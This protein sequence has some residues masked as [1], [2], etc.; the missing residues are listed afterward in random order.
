MIVID[1]LG[2]FNDYISPEELRLPSTTTSLEK[3]LTV[4]KSPWLWCCIWCLLSY[5]NCQTFYHAFQ[6]FTAIKVHYRVSVLIKVFLYVSQCERWWFLHRKSTVNPFLLIGIK[7]EVR[8]GDQGLLSLKE[9]P[10]TRRFK[11]F[12]YK[13]IFVRWP[14]WYARNMSIKQ[15]HFS[16]NKWILTILCVQRPFKGCPIFILIFSPILDWTKLYSDS[17]IRKA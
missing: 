5:T 12:K 10:N 9:T 13:L 11:N 14:E 15:V 4:S 2:K 7:D 6:V 16:G 8:S 1:N 3:D 17:D